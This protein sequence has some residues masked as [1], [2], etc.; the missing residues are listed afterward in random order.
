MEY[1]SVWL[2]PAVWIYIEFGKRER[3]MKDG[4]RNQSKN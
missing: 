2:M 3:L 4:Q 1:L